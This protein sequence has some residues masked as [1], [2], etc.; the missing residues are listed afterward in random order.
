MQ[1]IG[2]TASI[3]AA[4]IPVNNGTLALVVVF[5]HLV[6]MVMTFH[7]FAVHY[8]L[9]INMMVAAV[10]LH[11]D[12]HLAIYQ[13]QAEGYTCRT[14]LCADHSQYHYR[15]SGHLNE[16]LLHNRVFYLFVVA[17][18]GVALCLYRHRQKQIR[19]IKVIFL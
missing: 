4:I 2:L 8:L 15:Q 18:L 13:I 11:S 14:C 12:V 9:V 6:A 19:S 7:L 16:L 10:I 17:G 1:Y 3:L 5:L